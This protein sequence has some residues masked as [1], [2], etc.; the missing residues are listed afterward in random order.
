MSVKKSLSKKIFQTKSKNTSQYYILKFDLMKKGSCMVQL[1]F[2]IHYLNVILPHR[3]A[4]C[5]G[6]PQHLIFQG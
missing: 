1:P 6:Q 4:P 5:K 3:Q 2:M